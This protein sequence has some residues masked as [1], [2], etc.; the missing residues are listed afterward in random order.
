MKTQAV[1]AAGIGIGLLA[2]WTPGPARLTDLIA[3]QGTQHEQHHAAAADA[4]TTAQP[5]STRGNMM[6]GNMMAADAKLDDLVRKMNDAKGPA[7]TDAIA[8]VVNA[9]VE[10][11]RSMRGTMAGRAGMMQGMMPRPATTA[12][13]GTSPAKPDK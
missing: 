6:M 9:L 7:K 4:A 2:A 3:A 11:H 13:D 5:G 12:P 8:E 1:L 10:Q